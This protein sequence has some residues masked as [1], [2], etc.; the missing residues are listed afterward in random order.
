MSGSQNTHFAVYNPVC[1]FYAVRTVGRELQAESEEFEL[2]GQTLHMRVLLLVLVENEITFPVQ[3]FEVR[4]DTGCLIRFL[5]RVRIDIQ[6]YVLFLFRLSHERFEDLLEKRVLQL[7][8]LH[9][10]IE[11]GPPVHVFIE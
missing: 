9:E 8:V 5:L 7:V 3:R 2:V 10:V 11:S 1:P 4:L 6:F